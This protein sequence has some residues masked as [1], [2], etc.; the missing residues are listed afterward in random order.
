M[1]QTLISDLV[2]NIPSKK[3][4]TVTAR[5]LSK[6]MCVGESYIRRKIND[7][8]SNGIPICSTR[9]GYY[10]SYD[11]VDIANTVQFLNNRLNTQIKAINGL[12]E[13]LKGANY[14][15]AD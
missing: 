8:R 15:K 7:A 1:K 11:S 6:L 2:A 13:C 9:R 14:G 10:L 12:A 4:Q 3:E 5:E